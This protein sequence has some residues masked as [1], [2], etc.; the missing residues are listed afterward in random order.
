MTDTELRSEKLRILEAGSS[1]FVG[2]ANDLYDKTEQVIREYV[3]NA[4]DAN[5]KNIR[6]NVSSPF[7][8][9]VIEDDGNGMSYN[10]MRDKLQRMG[11]SNQF[12]NPDTIGRFGIGIV[13]ATTICEEIHI[14]SKTKDSSTKSIVSLPVGKWLKESRVN[15]NKNI[16]DLPEFPLEEINAEDDE[17]SKGFTI[18]QL[19]NIKELAQSR[20][21]TKVKKKTGLEDLRDRLRTILPLPMPE[22]APDR[23]TKF[24][25]GIPVIE[26]KKEFSNNFTIYFNGNQLTKLF[27][28]DVSKSKHLK[29]K[30]IEDGKKLIGVGWITANRESKTFSEQLLRGV[31]IR[32][33][34]VTVI[35]RETVYNIISTLKKKLRVQVR[36]RIIGEFHVV[37][38]S[39][40]PNQ[41]RNGFDDSPN[42]QFFLQEMSEIIVDFV[43]T[44]YQRDYQSK[45]GKKKTTKSQ[46][47]RKANKIM[48][49]VSN[50]DQLTKVWVEPIYWKQKSKRRARKSDKEKLKNPVSIDDFLEPILKDTGL[51]KDAYHQLYLVENMTRRVMDLIVRKQTGLPFNLGNDKLIINKDLKNQIGNIKGQRRT[52]SWFQEE[53]IPS[54][55]YYSN[56]EHLSTLIESN[57]THFTPYF[58]SKNITNLTKLLQD[59]E[60]LRNPVMHNAVGLTTD[61]VMNLNIIQKKLQ[62]LLLPIFA[63]LADEFGENGQ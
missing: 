57:R 61:I 18:V 44:I 39:I 36:E 34:N 50:T 33:H 49:V 54:D 37:D 56:F 60:E 28:E 7:E 45:T 16:Q 59:A 55:L 1:I 48:K 9:I 53:K 22:H 14:V 38:E 2:F 26:S 23:L 11:K 58:K 21:R 32:H 6:I 3:S 30:K 12:D 42:Y 63:K 31:Q 43:E 46:V 35:D 5:A 52:L 20:L 29:I 27:P 15:P 17:I 10:E 13:S 4:L 8:M 41:G 62:A 40:R 24:P 47:T 51:M 25:I 19:H